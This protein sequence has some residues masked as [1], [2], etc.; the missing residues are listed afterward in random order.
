MSEE[1]DENELWLD[2]LDCIEEL[3]Q[4]VRGNRRA[5]RHVR[6]L[7]MIVQQVGQRIIKLSG[8]KGFLR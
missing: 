5:T 2:L 4:D 8:K 7:S 6:N 3:K 1:A